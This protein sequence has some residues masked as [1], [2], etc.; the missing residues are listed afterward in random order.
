M[1]DFVRKHTKVLMFVMFLLIIPSFVLFGI[2]GY[3]SFRD[4]GEVV[5][6]VDGHDISQGDWDA[7]HRSESERLRTSM[8]NVDP[9]LLDSP[10]ARY[11]V[12]ERLVRERVMVAAAD[13]LRFS[14]SD[15][16]LAR[17]LQEIPQIAALR[18]ADGKLDMEAYSAL[19]AS[20]GLTPAGFEAR[21]RRDLSARQVEAGVQTTG[22]AA[23]TVADMALNA[24]FDKREV[25]I[26]QFNAADFAAKVTPTE[27]EI[28]AY[29][30]A[31]PSLFQAPEE[32]SVEYVTLDL[33][34]VKK[35]VVISEA[36]LK[37]YYEQNAAKLSG[38][39]ERRA[40]HIL[41]KAGKD[42]STAERNAAQARINE[43]LVQVKKAPA[44]FADMAKKNS[45]D[46]GS[47]V[48]GGDLDFFARGAMVK[49]FEDAAFALKKGEISAVVASDFGFHIIQLTDIKAPKQLSLEELRPSLEADLKT[50]QAK[51]KFAEAAEAFT[52]GV[53]EQG[54]SLK[55]V[56]DKLKLELKTAAKV[57][58]TPAPGVT[59]ALANAK[60]L[61]AVF[62]ADALE[63]KHNTEA[64]ETGPSQLS[65]AR[66]TQY[67]AA[68]V[69]PLSEV[70]TLVR[71]KLIALRAAELAKKEGETKLQAWKAAPASVSGLAAAVL[72]SR[73][74]PE[75]VA[76][77]IMAAVLRAPMT[78]L[79]SFV[80]V[81]L[82][83]QGY[84]VVKL[85]KSV[86]RTVIAQDQTK[87]ERGQYAQWWTAAETQAY[88]DALKAR[89]KVEILAPKPVV[90]ATDS[91]EVAAR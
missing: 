1:F 76:S 29:Y 33:E 41:I 4:Q 79:P 24:F 82:G 51:L 19:V 59:G 17:G 20:Q 87:Q 21:M 2:Q 47:A 68:H 71:D 12:L 45:Q 10:Q 78:S 69:L 55:P 74:Q 32:V 88:Y 91:S 54:D 86:P 44:S 39:E 81:D 64:I 58:R 8:P 28:E 37:T 61:D 77:A 89:F 35:T 31:N 66:V 65:A 36:D 16:R 50:S 48:N 63:K 27:A 38:T 60:L 9:K 34:A 40:S 22:F 57:S 67:V 85:N 7:A 80:G 53:Y 5:A 25:Q 13:Q 30:K 26:A 73:D 11:A 42:A 18:T 84:A 43:L 15:V 49:P 83:T 6:R 56:V 3:D 72:V 14:T 52:N 46:E 23:S 75:S 62:S 70:Q 90:A